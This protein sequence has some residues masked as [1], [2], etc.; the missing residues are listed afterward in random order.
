ML[1]GFRPLPGAALNKR[2]MRAEELLAAIAA[3][4]GERVC[5]PAERWALLL[6]L[7]LPAR[8]L[9]TT[10]TRAARIHA[11]L[12]HAVCANIACTFRSMG[13]T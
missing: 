9:F 13:G 10:D 4:T 1:C 8:R 7:G 2:I 6:L 12:R 5:V 3:T 11:V